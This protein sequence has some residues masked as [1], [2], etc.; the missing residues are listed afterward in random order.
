M[1]AMQFQTIHLA[2]DHAGFEHKEAVRAW[3]ESE[4]VTVV[5]HGTYELDTQDDFPVFMY[6]AG[7]AVQLGGATHGAI[8]F[9]GSGQGEAMAINRLKGIRAGVFYGGDL[10]LVS[11]MRQHNDANVLSI[12]ARFVALEDA[13]SAIWQWL[14]TEFPG[15]EKYSRRNRQIDAIS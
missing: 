14:H 8:I 1:T 7:Q 3:L 11:L 10:E 5:D 2:T 4:G 13:K 9:G 12:G 15:E 6:T